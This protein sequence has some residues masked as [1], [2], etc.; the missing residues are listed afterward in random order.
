M[1]KGPRGEKRPADAVARAVMVGKIATGE[2][3]DDLKP[4]S[5]RARSGYAGAAARNVATSAEKRKEIASKAASSRWSG[6]EVPMSEKQR[7]IRSLFERRDVELSN[8]KFFLLQS[9]GSVSEEVLCERVNKVIFE[10]D[11]GICESSGKFDGDS[12]KT[13]NVVELSKK[14]TQAAT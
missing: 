12:V 2:L 4:V 13:V 9:Q 11:A 7:L 8:I 10:I 3:E 1:A 14:L 5:G 6:K